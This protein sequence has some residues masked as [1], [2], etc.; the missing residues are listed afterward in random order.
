MRIYKPKWERA[1]KK[2]KG[3]KKLILP[4]KRLNKWHIPSSLKLL[5][6]TVDSGFE[7]QNK[8][9]KPAYNSVIKQ[10]KKINMGL[11]M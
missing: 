3:P 4:V 8:K 7:F 9:Q 6:V 11:I 2:R 5:G 1:K 10:E